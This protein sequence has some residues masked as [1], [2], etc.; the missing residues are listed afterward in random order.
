MLAVSILDL[1]SGRTL[2]NLP[3]V[4]KPMYLAL[5]RT[6]AASIANSEPEG[7]ARSADYAASI[8]P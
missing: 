5:H 7:D 6:G 3:A 1:A 2:T 4:D 8:S